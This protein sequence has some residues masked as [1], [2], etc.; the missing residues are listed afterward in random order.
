MLDGK[1]A[2]SKNTLHRLDIYTTHKVLERG[3]K[4]DLCP[5]EER[6]L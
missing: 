1:L 5:R 2:N 3:L 4:R 6:L